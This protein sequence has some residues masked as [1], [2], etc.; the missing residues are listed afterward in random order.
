MQLYSK[1]V[2]VTDV[3]RAKVAVEGIVQQSLVNAEVHGWE[4]LS[5]SGSGACLC[6]RGA[7]RWRRVLLGIR[8][9]CV[10]IWCVG[11]R[12]K[13]ESVLYVLEGYRLSIR[14]EARCFGLC[15][16]A[17]LDDLTVAGRAGAR[18]LCYS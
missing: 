9:R 8:E 3:K 4:R 16:G 17:N 10:R 5:A 15:Y 1:A 2:Q 6:P 11:V 7:L 14:P 12:G 18:R 13:I